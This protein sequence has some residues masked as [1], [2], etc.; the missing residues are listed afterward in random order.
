MPEGSTQGPIHIL[1]NC[2]EEAK[3][4]KKEIWI[5]SQDISKAFDSVNI[6]MLKKSMKRIKIPE[7]IIAILSKLID[8]RTSK[9]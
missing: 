2:I 3:E 9:V 1:N 6:D 5:L 7:E 4:F 8:N